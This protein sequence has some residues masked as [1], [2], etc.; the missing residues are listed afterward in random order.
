L[1]L[2]EDLMKQH[3]A[4]L[5]ERTFLRENLFVGRDIL[6]RKGNRLELIDGRVKPFD[7]KTDRL[8]NQDGS[9]AKDWREFLFEAAYIKHALRLTLP[10]KHGIEAHPSRYI[11]AVFDA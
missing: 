11:C 7:S 2:T 6:V 1:R 4:I 3:H 8:M 5:H 10:P 9:I